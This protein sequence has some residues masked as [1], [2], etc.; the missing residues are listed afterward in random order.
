[1]LDSTGAQIVVDGKKR[2]QPQLEW[3][4]RERGEAFSAAVIAALLKKYPDALDGEAA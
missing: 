2:Y 3:R 1:M 4:S